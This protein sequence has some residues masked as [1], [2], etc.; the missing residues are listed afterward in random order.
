MHV[1]FVIVG[2]GIAGISAAAH[3]APLGSL[4]VLEAE[5][6]LAYHAS[7]RSAALYEPHYGPPAIVALSQA[8]GAA[9]RSI[10]GGVLSPRGLLLVAGD[11]ADAFDADRRALALDEISVDEARRRVPILSRRAL[12]HAAY[13]DRAW[14]VDTDRLVQAYARMARQAGAQIVTGATVR[15][16]RRDGDLWVL[17]TTKGDY[18]ARVLVNAAGAWVDEIARM[19]GVR[20]LGFTPLRRSMARIPAPRGL[21]VSDWPMMFGAGETWYAKPDA[22]ALIVSPAEEHA[23]EPH[24]AW[25][26]DTVLAEGLARYEAMVDAPVERLL[27]SWAGLRTFSPDRSPVFGRDPAAPEFVWCAGQG[28]YGFQS[29]PAAAALLADLIAGGA[30]VIGPDLV[31]ALSVERYN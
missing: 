15:G 1:D 22:G 8:S 31:H 16:I 21:D 5:C 29:A 4:A 7:G 6:H 30:P 3:L 25:A 14:D 18:A 12:H 10:D 11:D 17:S 26:D 28:G 24:D 27:A 23:A 13:A 20:P 19:A 2:G 9:L